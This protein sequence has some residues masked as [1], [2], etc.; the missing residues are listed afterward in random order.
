MKN[1]AQASVAM[2]RRMEP[3][4]QSL[5]ADP[6]VAVAEDVWVLTCLD[7]IKLIAWPLYNVM[8]MAPATVTMVP[9][10]FAWHLTFFMSTISIL[11]VFS[12]S[13]S[14]QKYISCHSDQSY[15]GE[16][17]TT[18]K[19][20]RVWNREIITVPAKNCHDKCHRRQHVTHGTRKG[21]R[22]EFQPS[23]VKVLINH[24]PVRIRKDKRKRLRLTV[25]LTSKSSKSLEPCHAKEKKNTNPRRPSTNIC[26]K[27]G[28][29]IFGRTF[30]YI[31]NK[32][33]WWI[34][35]STKD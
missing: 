33:T 11:Y 34:Y 15:K 2:M 6:V 5:S 4:S 18:G 21:G 3:I 10:T 23:I 8:N 1:D 9:I 20:N 31:N 19:E 29:V 14:K 24:G 7:H 22:S 12:T 16:V 28:N 26:M 25:F 13:P 32:K 17:Q 30:L 27:M 35:F